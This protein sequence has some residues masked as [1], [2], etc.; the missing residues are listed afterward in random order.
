[1]TYGRRW[2]I[3]I[4]GFA[5][6]IREE[7]AYPAGVA[8]SRL[9]VQTE[10]CTTWLLLSIL[11]LYKGKSKLPEIRN[12]KRQDD[13]DLCPKSILLDEYLLIDAKTW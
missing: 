12:Q 9:S 7:T 1:M 11:D 13:W 4:M 2:S 10:R 3:H 6:R 8:C 5:R